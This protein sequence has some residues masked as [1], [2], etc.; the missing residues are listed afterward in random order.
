MTAHLPVMLNEV[1]T[2]LAI[3]PE[4]I[5]LDLTI[6]RGG[7]SR[8]IIKKLT[9]GQLLGFDQDAEAIAS[10]QS[11]MTAHPNFQLYHQNFMTMDAVLK[12]RGITAVDGILLDL[13]VSSPQFD[14]PARGFSYREDGP[15]DMRMDQRQK[16]TAAMILATYDVRQLTTMMQKHADETFAYP[17]AKAI[18]AQRQI[19]PI[20]TTFALVDLIKKTKP[21]K[22]LQKKGHPAK[23]V[24][25]ALRIEVNQEDVAL[26]KVLETSMRI[27]KP[28]GRLVVISF[29]SGEDRIVK[30][31]FREAAVIEG[32]RTGIESIAPI[33]EKLFRLIPPVPVKPSKEE[34]N[35]NHRSESAI[36]RIIERK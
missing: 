28:Q 20:T 16:L 5:Y 29:H 32:S 17:I 30:T 19:Q 2:G 35:L 3:K 36:L 25:Q 9:T 34:I 7:H 4:G 6:G 23:Q 8:N 24:F 13:G 22:A 33:E 12:S 31:M 18:I 26:K 21:A 14:N 1:I 15:L 11:W 27:L 10:L